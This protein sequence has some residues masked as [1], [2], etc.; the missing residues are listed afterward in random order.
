MDEQDVAVVQDSLQRASARGVH[1]VRYFYA[2]L[3]GS[4]PDLRRLFPAELGEQHERL[5]NALLHVITHLDSP[6]TVSY[7]QRLGRDHRRYGIARRDYLSV[8]QSLI[9]SIAEHT[10]R[11]WNEDTER[12]W[13]NV[14]GMAMDTM[15]AAAQQDKDARRPASWE[16]T[17]V[18][19]RLDRTGHTVVLQMV[20]DQPYAFRPGQYAAVHHPE[21]RG[22]WRPYSLLRPDDDATRGEV[23]LHIARTPHGPLS[24]LLCDRTFPGQSLTVSTPGGDG[25]GAQDTGPLTLIAA[26]TGWAPA[27][28]VLS[29][30]VQRF[31]ARS[32]DLHIVARS[33]DHFYDQSHLAQLES[34]HHQLTCH[35]WWPRDPDRV[36]GFQ[37]AF[38]DHLA[39]ERSLAARHVYVAGPPAFV[40]D[41]VGTLEEHNRPLSVTHDPL[42]A[43]HSQAPLTHAERVLDPPRPRWVNPSLHHTG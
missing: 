4:R 41:T 12:A 27:R 35:W 28:A 20:P 22:V 24:A 26:G 6:A 7:L 16:A 30:Q 2:H 3:F 13:T 17:V 19:R 43:E 11:T 21:L 36:R 32:I 39:G 25:W 40:R 38:Q 1:V 10:P 18:S 14:Y 33:R 9:A 37:R 15:L 29:E 31:P 42:P 23:E 8:G 5:L 34:R